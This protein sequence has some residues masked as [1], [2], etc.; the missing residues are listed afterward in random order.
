[1]NTYVLVH[2]MFLGG[3]CWARVVQHLITAGHRVFTPT[4]TGLGERHHL[5]SP[6]IGMDTFIQ[7]L[8]NVIEFEDLEQVILVG[9]S[10]GGMAATGAA[11]AMPQRIRRLVY[12]DG[13]IP[14]PGHAF[15]E[16][17]PEKIRSRRLAAAKETQGTRCFMPMDPRLM[18]IKKSQ[19]LNWLRRHMTPHPVKTYLDPIQLSQAPAQGPPCTYIRCTKP[20]YPPANISGEQARKI[21]GWHYLE[22]AESHGCIIN[23][24]QTVAKLL[25]KIPS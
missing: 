14:L 13:A 22:I 11:D 23:A 8:V 15:A 18:G 4:Q 2:G 20:Y 3:W 7:D 24:A 12:L 9:H 6:S 10:F 1:M 19:E 5:L 25:Q 16:Q 21:P 17:L